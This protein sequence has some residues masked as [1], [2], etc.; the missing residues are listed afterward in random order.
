[1]NPETMLEL[2]KRFRTA[3]CYAWGSRKTWRL[4]DPL[5]TEYFERLLDPARGASTPELLVWRLD[6]FD[7]ARAR[8]DM[9][10]EKLLEVAIFM[11]DIGRKPGLASWYG[12]SS[13]F[14]ARFFRPGLSMKIDGLLMSADS[15]CGINVTDRDG[16]VLRDLASCHWGA[17]DGM[18]TVLI[19]AMAK[20]W[21]ECYGWTDFA[22]HACAK[23]R[24]VLRLLSEGNLF[25]NRHF[26]YHYIHPAESNLVSQLR[27]TGGLS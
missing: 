11:L 4:D 10:H 3:L 26:R 12:A 16:L 23:Y 2:R 25:V 21:V 9:K 19:R 20:E 14:A 6:A 5:I 17:P 22:F 15:L 7:R 24:C 13:S 1:M 27:K 8:C 18:F